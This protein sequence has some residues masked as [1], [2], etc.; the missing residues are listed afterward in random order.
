MASPK[1]TRSTYGTGEL[2]VKLRPGA[3]EAKTTFLHAIKESHAE[4]LGLTSSTQKKEG[5]GSTAKKQL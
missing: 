1:S 5:Q 3:K 2:G 4:S